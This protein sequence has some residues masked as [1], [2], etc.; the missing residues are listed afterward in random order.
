[1]HTVRVPSRSFRRMIDRSRLTDKE[2]A[3]IADVSRTTVYRWRIGQATPSFGEVREVTDRVQSEA[4]GV[5]QD[6][7]RVWRDLRDIRRMLE[8]DEWLKEGYGDGD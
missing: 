2:I 4:R 8:V 3:H 1:M 6:A 7:K 5:M